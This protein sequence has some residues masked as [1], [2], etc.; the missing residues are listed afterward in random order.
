MVTSC[1][2]RHPPIDET[3]L[4]ERSGKAAV[5]TADGEAK[6]AGRESGGPEST[7]VHRKRDGAN[8][9]HRV[10]PLNTVPSAGEKATARDSVIDGRTKTGARGVKL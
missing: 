5:S 3:H 4:R 10:K 1:K 7:T 8:G 6:L 2:P 9:R